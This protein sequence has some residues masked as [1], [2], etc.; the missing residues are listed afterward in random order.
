MD[1]LELARRGVALTSG[2]GVSA[3]LTGVIYNTTPT[4]TAYQKVTV[5]TAKIV[6][7][8]I[9]SEH[10]DRYLERKEEDLRIWWTENIITKA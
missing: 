9:I 4:E 3:I 1:K 8:F 2:M 6:L 7:G 5:G 10:V